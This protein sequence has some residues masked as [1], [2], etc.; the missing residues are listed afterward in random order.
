M[1]VSSFDKKM[2]CLVA[3][4][5]T[6]LFFVVVGCTPEQV[7]EGQLFC[8]VK[9]TTVAMIDVATNKP[10]IVT[11]QEKATV[12]AI[13]DTINGIAVVPPPV[14]SGAVPEVAVDVAKVV[15]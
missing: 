5:A 15:K 8:A 3:I 1:S 7:K 4:A 9:D 11:G 13:C 2:S 10:F 14:G 12:D 6:G